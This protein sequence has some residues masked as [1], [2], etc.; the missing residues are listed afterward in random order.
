MANN[1]RI[2]AVVVPISAQESRVHGY[3][4]S[5]ED[6]FAHLELGFKF[7][8]VSEMIDGVFGADV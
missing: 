4:I 6:C 7:Y 2:N 5:D 3:N 8:N 1:F